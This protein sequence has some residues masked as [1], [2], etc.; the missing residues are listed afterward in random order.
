M[1]AKAE[2]V[3]IIGLLFLVGTVGAV[4]QV[5]VTGNSS[6]LVAGSGSSAAYTVTVKNITSNVPIQGATITFLVDPAYGTMSP[7][8]VTTNSIG[9]AVST[10]TVNTTSGTAPILASINYTAGTVGEG[11]FSINKTILQNIDHG[12]PYYDPSSSLPL[13]TYP[14]EGTV[15]T[16]IPFKISMYD[17]WGNPIDNRNPLDIH[18]IGL[19][20]SSPSYRLIA[21]LMMGVFTNTPSLAL[22]KQMALCLSM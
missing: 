21:D 2:I 4:I 7:A 11:P 16:E 13:F 22:W 6:W 3:V 17:S 19:Q 14:E 1:R 9:Q 10:F 15:A 5:D 12:T 8:P 20:V 18:T